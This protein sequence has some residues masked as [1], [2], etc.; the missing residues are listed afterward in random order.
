MLSPDSLPESLPSP[1]RSGS[2]SSE[3]KSAADDSTHGDDNST[4]LPPIISQSFVDRILWPPTGSSEPQLGVEESPSVAFSD[5]LTARVRASIEYAFYSAE[6]LSKTIF[7][8]SVTLYCPVPLGN[9]VLDSMLKL[10]ADQVNADVIELDALELVSGSLGLDTTAV[11]AEIS[12]VTSHLTRCSIMLTEA[13][14][15]TVLQMGKSQ[16]LFIAVWRR[17]R[18]SVKTSRHSSLL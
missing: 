10:V 6:R 5:G 3:Y 13:Q 2:P 17:G 8:G 18:T 12:C 16:G 9:P 7:A 14:C 11:E 1:D 15:T 4:H